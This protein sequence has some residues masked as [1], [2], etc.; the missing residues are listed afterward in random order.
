MRIEA[1]TPKEYIPQLPPERQKV[2]RKLRA[3]VRKHIPKGFKETMQYAM[4]SW[5]VP[6]SIYP[7]GYHC[8]PTQPLPF[9]SIASQKN[10]VALYHMG[11]YAM[12]ALLAWFKEEYPH[13]CSTKLDMGKSCIRFKKLDDVPYELIGQLMTK[14]TTDDIVSIHDSFR[15]NK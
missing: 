12:P 9:V 4:I 13:H 5:V 3:T 14:L 15:K 10:Y 11:I 6:H 2:L 7:A 8:D 1:D